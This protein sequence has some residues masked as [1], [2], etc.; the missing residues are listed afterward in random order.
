MDNITF[1]CTD[2]ASAAGGRADRHR[3]SNRISR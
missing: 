3:D 2:K 1:A